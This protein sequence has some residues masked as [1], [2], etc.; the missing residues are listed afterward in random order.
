M[1]LSSRAL[2]ASLLLMALGVMTFLTGRVDGQLPLETA[3]NALNEDD[4]FVVS[5]DASPR[6]AYAL[7]PTPEGLSLVVQVAP[8]AKDGTGTSLQVGLSAAKTLI[9][10]GA[11]ARKSF[12]DGVVEYAFLIPKQ[13]LIN[14]EADWSQLRFGL[15]VSWAGGPLGEDRQRERFLHTGGAPSDGLSPNPAGWMPLD[16]AEH[17]DLV[18]AR[19]NRIFVDLDQPMD[20]KVTVVI[21]DDK[22][23][24]V[25]NLVSGLSVTQGPQRFPWDGMDENGSVVAPGTYHWRAISHPGIVPQY[26]FSFYNHGKPP[27]RDPSPT[28]NW[29]EDESNPVAAA[30]F[31]DHV[32]VGGPQAESNHN[33]AVLDLEGN[34][35]A[36]LNLPTLVGVGKMFL[37]SDADSFYA[38]MEGVPQYEPFHD[39]PG[40]QWEFRRPLNILHWELNAKPLKYDGARGEKVVTDNMYTGSGPHGVH[41]IRG[42][43]PIA[44]NLAGAAVLNGRI[45]V[46]LR[47]ENRIAILD[48]AIG[49][50]LDEIKMDNPGLIATDGSSFLVAFSGNKLVQIDPET[51]AITPLFTPQLSPRPALG[52]PEEPYYG[53]LHA[54]PTGMT[55]GADH[56][57][58]LSDNGVD[59]DIKVFDVTGRQLLEIGKKGGRPLVGPWDNNGVYQPHGI[60][61]DSAGKL[62]VTE[63]DDL[64]RRVSVWDSK[65]GAFLNQFFGP[66]Y[67]GAA[68][69]SI[70]P[71]DHTRWLGGG[72]Q[73][74]LD[75]DQK[76]ATPVST[77][78][79]QTKAGQLQNQMQGM[80][81]NFYRTN[82][83]TFL[84]GYGNGQC[85]YELKADG[86]VKLWAFCASIGAIAQFPRWTLPKAITDLPAVQAVFAAN[87]KT[88][89][90]SLTMEPYGDW[91]DR[92]MLDS[93]LLRNINL[94][95]VDKNGNDLGETDEFE[96]LPPGDSFQSV[97]WGSGSLDLTLHLPATIG[98]KLVL[99]NLAPNGFL[100]SGAPN[101]SLA[102]AIKTAVPLDPIAPSY[103]GSFE[104]VHDRQGREIFN[105][106]PMVG[107][108]P[109]GHIQWSIANNFSGVHGAQQ[110]PLPETGVLQGVL[111]F[112]GIAP[113][114]DK[115]DVFIMNND[116]GRFFAI[117]SDGFYLD[118]MFKDVRVTQ[119]AD[120]Y[121]IGGEPFGGYFTKCEDGKYYLQSGHTDYR[122][123][124]INGLDQLKR[125]EGVIQVSQAQI[126]AAQVNSEHHAAEKQ[127]AKIASVTEIPSTT[128][129]AADPN[130]WPGDWVHWGDQARPFP[131]AEVKIA[132]QGDLLD[133]AY[134]V[135][136]PSPWVNHGTDDKLLFKT[137]DSIDFD[138]STD[139]SAK[140]DRT[141]PVP[142]DR[143]LLIAPF[144]DKSIAV[145]Y[146]YR[147]PG[148]KNPVP[149]S[150]PV[151]TEMVD[152][153]TELPSATISVKT[154]VGSYMI[155]VSVPLADLGLP[156]T[157]QTAQLKGDFG[158]IYGDSGGTIDLLRSYWSNKAT[159]LVNDIPGEVSINP[160]L[161]GTLQFNA[162]PT[163]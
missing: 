7:T 114:D 48:A 51:K 152:R 129:L 1:K 74:K 141:K 15:A 162:A 140:P 67:Y 131:Y 145:L 104:C 85:V 155:T 135:K 83:R 30:A 42:Q 54:N 10:K 81:W 27:W 37:L 35:T 57:I 63:T 4:F 5:G 2:A 28:S 158:V 52:D 151:G 62:W 78:Y 111:Y 61:L 25:R 150:S 75:F 89:H 116:H 157:G 9:L 58:F 91:N 144:Q 14:Q 99:L 68:Q 98:G 132:R 102:D 106:T 113:L 94:L 65:T 50:Q 88:A 11:D 147:E 103:E 8:F 137:G 19:K 87:A 115:S 23:H 148:A 128:K 118:E 143:R 82:G 76:T 12:R 73:W 47:A 121:M 20:G 71:T 95:W 105:S 59:Q 18:L 21:E 92:V 154:D 34:K 107:V 142:G 134:R 41:P 24:R 117:T 43:V 66:E 46:S 49:G 156:A 44:G 97:G 72:V 70:D 127:E 55:V 16:L 40:G 149:F 38:V 90:T 80:Y 159:G 33:I 124:Q 32:V 69:G 122:I 29:I 93:N 53:F 109:D 26:L 17:Q 139:P 84:I 101:Y 96:F 160:R 146:S 31:G 39:L 110:A 136:D 126:L 45:Y 153:V 60:A 133:L 77:L 36:G 163:P 86:S 22:G 125:S 64:P 100:P 112:L 108:T 56:R 6:V 130:N 79:H 3:G 119:I 123:F 138:F 13:D 120:A 161:W